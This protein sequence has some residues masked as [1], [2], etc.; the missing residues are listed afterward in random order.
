MCWRSAMSSGE[1]AGQRPRKAYSRPHGEASGV[2]RRRGLL[3]GEIDGEEGELI[4]GKEGEL[5]DN[6]RVIQGEELRMRRP[7]SARRRR[8]RWRP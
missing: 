2:V 1:P 8:R 7:R 6:V 4:D 5:A 3:G